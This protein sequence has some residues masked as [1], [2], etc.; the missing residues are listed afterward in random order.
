M[1]KI[2]FAMLTAILMFGVTT[3]AS[4]QSKVE[5]RY[6]YT[7]KNLKL[8]KATEAKFSPVLMA[9]L[10]E[11]KEAGDIYDDVKDKYRAAAKAGTLTDGQASQLLDAKLASEEKQLAVRKKYTAEF[12]K[13]LKPKKVYYA[14]DFATEKIS[15]IDGTK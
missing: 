6:A 12:K 13:Y 3:T 5:K 9:F 7:M 1:K 11:N 2:I 15:K 4:A 14:I 8:D 10:K